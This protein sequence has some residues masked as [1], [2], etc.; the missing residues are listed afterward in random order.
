MTFAFLFFCS[1][2]CYAS[3]MWV[4][5]TAFLVASIAVVL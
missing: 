1:M 3:R 2:F 4:I 5:G